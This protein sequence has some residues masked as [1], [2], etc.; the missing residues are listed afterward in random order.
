MYCFVPLRHRDVKYAP[1]TLV[2]FKQNYLPYMYNIG[3]HLFVIFFHKRTTNTRQIHGFEC[4]IILFITF[5]TVSI[6]PPPV[7]QYDI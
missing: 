5:K 3:I 1:P 2:L 6:A 7:T 4:D